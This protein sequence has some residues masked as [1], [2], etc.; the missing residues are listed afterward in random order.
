MYNKF[1]YPLICI[2]S[3]TVFQHLKAITEDEISKSFYAISSLT[4]YLKSKEI[5]NNAIPF[6]DEDL[7]NLWT[8][9]SLNSSYLPEITQA[10]LFYYEARNNP[11]KLKIDLYN[12]SK[13][14]LVKV[15]KNVSREMLNSKLSFSNPT[16]PNIINNPYINEEIKKQIEPFLLPLNH[17]MNAPL[18][19]IFKKIRA[20]KDPESFAKAGFTTF[21][22]QQ[23]SFIRIGKHTLL[24]GYLLKVYL[25]T[26]LRMKENRPGWLWLARRCEGALNIRKLIQKKKMKH[27][28][29][30][31]KFLY[32][33]PADP[34]AEKNAQ[35]IILIVTDMKVYSKKKSAI[36]WKTKAT[37]EVLDE[38]YSIIS[39]GYASNS[40]AMNIPYTKTGKFSCID[41]ETPIKIPTYDKL[42][43]FFS[44]PMQAY[45]DELVRSGGKGKD[46]DLLE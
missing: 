2:I 23:V 4:Y 44:E 31:D 28:S 6:E 45:W 17:P 9:A 19:S 30:P 8:N 32:P 20:I 1:L 42:R 43:P 39:H 24:P 40:L 14:I 27:F 33:L 7:I 35:P 16:H 25:D 11:D 26:E 38:L 46:L 22:V 10:Q 12:K 36:Y 3:F 15:W 21:S 13:N 29:V 41:T 37:P 34:P 5:N 18:D